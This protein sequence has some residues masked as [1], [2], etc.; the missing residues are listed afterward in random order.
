LSALQELDVRNNLL[1]KLPA[2]MGA[3]KELEYLYLNDNH[4]KKLPETLGELKNLKLLHI[5]RNHIE[6]PVP[7]FIGNLESLVELDVSGCCDDNQLPSTLS[8]LRRLE[9]L[10]VSSYQIIPYGIGTGN[11]RLKIIV[12]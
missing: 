12:R 5:G 3:L 8:Q 2:N 4:L 7:A 9:I 1:T 11:T 10:Y 6:G